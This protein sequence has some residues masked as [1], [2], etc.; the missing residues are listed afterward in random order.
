MVVL[1]E[2]LGGVG[3]FVL[4]NVDRDPRRRVET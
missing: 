3:P 2:K 1:W 4:A